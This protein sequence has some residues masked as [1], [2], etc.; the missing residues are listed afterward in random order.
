MQ[1]IS[2]TQ[3]PQGYSIPKFLDQKGYSPNFDYIRYTY[4]D[5]LPV[6]V[7]VLFTNDTFILYIVDSVLH[8]YQSTGKHLASD[9]LE[10][11]EKFLQ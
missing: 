1:L 11:F 2:K 7:Y 4:A 6:D 3:V 9:V 5:D 8:I 10:L